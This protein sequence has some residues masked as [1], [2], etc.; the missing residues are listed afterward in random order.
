MLKICMRQVAVIT[1]FVA[2]FCCALKPQDSLAREENNYEVDFSY[3]RFFRLNTPL[4]KT[5]A[6]QWMGVSFR[7]Q[8]PDP[9]FYWDGFIDIDTRLYLKGGTE[10]D[11]IYSAPE[12]YI[13][14]DDSYST[15]AVEIDENGNEVQVER[16]VKALFSFGRRLLDWNEHERYWQLGYLNGQQGF[17]LLGEKQEGLT[18]IHFNADTRVFRANIF[19]SY[20][21]I[22]SLNPSIGEE[23]GRIT[24]NSEWVRLPPTQTIYNGVPAEIAYQINEPKIHRVLLNKSLGASFDLKWTQE[25]FL[26]AY[27]IYKPENKIRVNAQAY[28]DTAT[29][30]V[31]V[32]ANP[33]VNHHLLYGLQFHQNLSQHFNFIAGID[34]NDPNARLGK[35]FDV[36][37]PVQLREQNRTFDSEFFRI[38]PSYDRESYAHYS[39]T[40]NNR[41]LILGSHYIHLISDNERGNDDFFSDTVKWKS[42]LGLYGKYFVTDK[43]DILVDWRYD[44]VREDNILKSETSYFFWPNLHFSLGFELLKAPDRN[45][46]WSAYRANDI[47]YTGVVYTY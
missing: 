36:L 32:E 15:S 37:D 40:Y 9:R 43:W 44:F 23:N 16:E 41:R 21:F 12:F 18:G 47:V 6:D 20:L 19:F 13:Q 45:S 8:R 2:G 4:N 38:L 28:Y 25:G 10:T 26:R 35:D 27:A 42:A 33:V 7:T 17:A 31:Q 39:L 22:P 14:R 24:S 1:L 11:F 5:A 3:E 46:Y 34:V 30:K 29:G